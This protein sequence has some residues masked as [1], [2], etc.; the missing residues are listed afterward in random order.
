M[1]KLWLFA[2]LMIVGCSNGCSGDKPPHPA[3]IPVG[4]ICEKAQV[5]LD[6]LKCS[7][8]VNS[9]GEP[10]ASSCHYL[11]DTGYPRIVDVAVCV[12]SKG[13]CTEAEQCK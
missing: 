6:D 10:W 3:P 4:D 2:A 8:R 13:S 7:W 5:K 12:A 1:T 9:K 11:A